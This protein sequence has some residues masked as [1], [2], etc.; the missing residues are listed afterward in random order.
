VA[1]GLSNKQVAEQLYV[2]VYTV[3]A[4]PSKAY[5]KPRHRLPRLALG[6]PGKVRDLPG[7][8]VKDPRFPRLLPNGPAY[9]GA[10]A[11]VPGRDLHSPAHPLRI[12][13]GRK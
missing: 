3:E 13:N 4:R 11:Q 2:T 8:A 5:A 9:G 7:R 10:H 12:H 6:P 1:A